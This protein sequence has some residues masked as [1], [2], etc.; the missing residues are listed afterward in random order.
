MC[1][2][3]K[4]ADLSKRDKGPIRRLACSSHARLREE[5][6]K[7][8]DDA[9]ERKGKLGALSRR[10]LFSFFLSFGDAK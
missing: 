2:A 9:D 6:E 1:Q 3:S 5:E 4:A 10:K 8:E 7:E